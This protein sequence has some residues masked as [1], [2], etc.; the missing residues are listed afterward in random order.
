MKIT[1]TLLKK[2]YNKRGG[3]K[4][5]NTFVLTNDKI[6]VNTVQDA[7]KEPCIFSLPYFDIQSVYYNKKTNKI[8]STQYSKMTDAIKNYLEYNLK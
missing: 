2:V 7:D 8:E 1:K 6:M 4:I 3:T 5:K